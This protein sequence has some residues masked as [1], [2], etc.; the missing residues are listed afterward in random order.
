VTE[1]IKY[2]GWEPIESDL[3][4]ELF[5]AMWQVELIQ[6]I[7][8][9]IEDSATAKRLRFALFVFIQLYELHRPRRTSSLDL[10]N[11]HMVHNA[12][13]TQQVFSTYDKSKADAMQALGEELQELETDPRQLI[14]ESR[15][16]EWTHRLAF[17]KR[18]IGDIVAI[19]TQLVSGR[20]QTDQPVPRQVVDALGFLIAGTLKNGERASRLSVALEPLV[21][22]SVQDVGVYLTEH[23]V[24]D[25][26]RNPQWSSFDVAGPVPSTS[27]LS[28]P[29]KGNPTMV[30]GASHNEFIVVPP[31]PTH[32]RQRDFT[33]ATIIAASHGATIVCLTPSTYAHVIG[34]SDCTIFLGPVCG[35]LTIEHSEKIRIVGS[36]FRVRLVNCVDVKM[37]L[38]SG[39]RPILLGD[40]RGVVA[41]PMSARYP[42]V[43][44]HCESV[45][46]PDLVISSAF[47]PWR[48]PILT[49]AGGVDE[50]E[51]EPS[52]FAIQSV[53]DF[54]LEPVG[55]A[56]A[57]HEWSDRPPEDL[58]APP[59]PAEYA[60]KLAER[61]KVVQKCMGMMQEA[62]KS[63]PSVKADAQGAVQAAF[64]DWLVASG[65][66]DQ[67]ASRFV[68]AAGSSSISE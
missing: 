43:S 50:D 1:Q 41:G 59:L 27:S 40:C 20:P 52:V 48:H 35:I 65:N 9:I 46:P 39:T 36:C 51:L 53:D 47:Q 61:A 25:E 63:A 21:G 12:P 57:A 18:R 6:N 4:L 68:I 55:A 67:I 62:V 30:R 17:C 54:A 24:A 26:T 2:L 23:I 58:A 13:A 29:Q 28:P 34:C 38:W 42:L 31:K 8:D 5:D 44:K 10:F 7:P 64:R 49:D 3:H 60:T 14:L 11:I 16:Q 22:K 45:C 56:L 32:S 37:N 33:S 66:M 15:K 19:L